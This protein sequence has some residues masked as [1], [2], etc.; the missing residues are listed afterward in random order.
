MVHSV[1]ED[2]VRNAQCPRCKQEVT[3]PW[4]S[5]FWAGFHYLV[6]QCGSCDYTLFFR[7]ER[8][9]DGAH[10]S[11]NEKFH[12]EDRLQVDRLRLERV[13]DTFHRN[14]LE[15]RSHDRMF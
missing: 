15:T 8:M 11:H 3:N 1:L 2:H 9:S 6:T 13:R 10:K 5:E 14:P 7:E 4:Q 12:D